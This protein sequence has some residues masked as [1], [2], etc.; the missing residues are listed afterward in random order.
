MNHAS[1]LDAIAVGTA[2][3]SEYC[4]VSA[5]IYQNVPMMGF[6]LKVRQAI[7]C[8]RGGSIE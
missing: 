7:F 8:E 1:V 3:G 6:L 2:I 5:D 4:N